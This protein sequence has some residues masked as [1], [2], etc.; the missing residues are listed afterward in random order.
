MAKIIKENVV[1][2]RL[3]TEEAQEVDAALENDKIVGVKSKGTLARKLVLDHARGKLRWASKRDKQ[4]A[5]EISAA[6]STA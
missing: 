4:L 6:K 3:T 5:P 2:F 1:A